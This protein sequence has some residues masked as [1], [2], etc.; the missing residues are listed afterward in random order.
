VHLEEEHEMDNCTRRPWSPLV[1]KLSQFVPL[2]DTD[3]SVL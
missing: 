2:S 3:V 1:T